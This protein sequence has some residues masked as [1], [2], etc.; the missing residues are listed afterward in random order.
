MAEIVDFGGKRTRSAAA[1][2][3]QGDARVEAVDAH[4]QMQTGLFCLRH[5]RAVGTAVQRPA[6]FIGADIGLVLAVDGGGVHAWIGTGCLIS[7]LNR[8]YYQ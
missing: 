4:F 3:R 5:E 1:H 8:N 6:G 7:G 2:P